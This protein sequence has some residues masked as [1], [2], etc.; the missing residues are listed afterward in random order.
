MPHDHSTFKLPNIYTVSGG[1]H[2]STQL[3]P[4]VTVN[5]GDDYANSTAAQFERDMGT[6][7]S[8]R[9]PK[10]LLRNTKSR[11]TLR[12][13]TASISPVKTKSSLGGGGRKFNSI[14]T[15]G[16]GYVDSDD[17]VGTVEGPHKGP[18]QL[19]QEIN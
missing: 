16:R 12:N 17:D 7:A 11:A 5:S 9:R 10:S 1:D 2:M 19:R 13:G 14:V 6:A 3:L 8:S 15:G 4:S 18:D